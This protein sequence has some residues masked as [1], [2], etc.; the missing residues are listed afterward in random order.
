ML[1]ALSCKLWNASAIGLVSTVRSRGRRL[2]Q[3]HLSNVAIHPRSPTNLVYPLTKRTFIDSKPRPAKS[4][5]CI[6]DKLDKWELHLQNLLLS[7]G[8]TNVSFTP[9]QLAH[10]VFEHVQG[11]LDNVI[12][13]KSPPDAAGTIYSTWDVTM[14]LACEN[15]SIHETLLAFMP[16]FWKLV[17][18]QR[19][20]DC[21][22][23][24][25]YPPEGTF[26]E[27]RACW[28][29][30]CRFIALFHREGIVG[31]EPLL[32]Q[33]IYD[34]FGG[35]KYPTYYLGSA[36]LAWER[37]MEVLE[38]ALWKRVGTWK[39][40]KEDVVK[41]WTGWEERLRLIEEDMKREVVVREAAGRTRVLMSGIRERNQEKRVSSSVE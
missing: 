36:V 22:H 30:I 25:C 23:D 7:A 34:V 18:K 39:G 16:E 5:S 1:Y 15:F 41:L 11:R 2:Y 29:K 14:T 27:K 3:R 28:V 26:A 19:W 35:G 12:T 17:Q 9:T 24:A 32:Q 31:A 21:E 38:Q 33:C 20:D 8:N 37:I 6:Y 4:D 13:P 40:E 10:S